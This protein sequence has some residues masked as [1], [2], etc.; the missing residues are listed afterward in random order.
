MLLPGL[1]AES[2][3]RWQLRASHLAL[4]EPRQ[5]VAYFLLEI[6]MRLRSVGIG[7]QTMCPFHLQRWQLA[8][9][10]GISQVHLN[11]TLRE[12]RAAGVLDLTRDILVIPDANK[13][14]HEANIAMKY[15]QTGQTIL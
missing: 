6:F 5:R 1:L 10:N 2:S 12:L 13:L 15:D 3:G 4:R 11:R 14:Q 7:D 8:E 9:A